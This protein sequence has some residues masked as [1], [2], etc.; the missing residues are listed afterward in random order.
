MTE[1]ARI[2]AAPQSVISA[3][4]TRLV[5]VG[6]LADE[7]IGRTRLV[8][9]NQEYR[10]YDPLTEILAATFG[11]EPVLT[12]LLAPVRDIEAAYLYGSWAARAKGVRGREP[13]DVDV[14]VIGTPAR[15]DLNAVTAD[16][17][18]ALGIEVQIT[19]VSAKAWQQATEPFI[20]T[21]QSSPHIQLDL[22]ETST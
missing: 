9:A 22:K 21:V 11:P 15:E 3:E 2:L 5:E 14:L 12:R 10:L 6:V 17:E 20:K 13:G 1:L 4:V 18:R 19:R 8:R 7:R 16:A